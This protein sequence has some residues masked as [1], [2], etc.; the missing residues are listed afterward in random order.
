MHTKRNLYLYRRSTHVLIALDDV[1]HVIPQEV[2]T[3][4]VEKEKG[5]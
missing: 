4:N 2:I 5:Y 1:S 3:F